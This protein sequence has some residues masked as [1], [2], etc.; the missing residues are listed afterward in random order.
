MAAARIGAPIKARFYVGGMHA[1]SSAVCPHR[2][3][4]KGR[5]EILY[6]PPLFLC[7]HVRAL[8]IH[9][10]VLLQLSGESSCI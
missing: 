10:S 9:P 1:N 5:R 4:D 8:I 2:D 3:A 6:P 7:L